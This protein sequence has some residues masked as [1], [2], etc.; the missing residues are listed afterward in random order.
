MSDEVLKRIAERALRQV[1]S[2]LEE[3]EKKKIKLRRNRETWVKF[4]QLP[5]KDR[6]P[7]VPKN[8]KDQYNVELAEF[9]FKHIDEYLETSDVE[10][11]FFVNQPNEV[12]FSFRLRTVCQW[13]DDLIV[14]EMTG[15]YIVKKLDEAEH[16]VELASVVPGGS[17]EHST[18]KRRANGVHVYTYVNCPHVQVYY[19]EGRLTYAAIPEYDADGKCVGTTG[20]GAL[21]NEC[22]QLSM[23]CTPTIQE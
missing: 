14:S 16:Y 20:V 3:L 12:P 7:S 21:S 6:L 11:S 4:H 13:N 23:W 22:S 10:W 15:T 9:V 17:Y 18:K 5:A 8:S 1:D 19:N 2:D